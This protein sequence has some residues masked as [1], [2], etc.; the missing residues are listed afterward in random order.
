MYWDFAF[1]YR[2]ICFFFS[3]SD[4]YIEYVLLPYSTSSANQ[5]MH[6]LDV[7][8]TPK[9]P[10]VIRFYIDKVIYSIDEGMLFLQTM[11][12]LVSIDDVDY[13]VG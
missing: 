10:K 8:Q 5:E 6:I 12:M 13:G 7:D 4:Q 3:L 9:S 1:S 2:I 11:P